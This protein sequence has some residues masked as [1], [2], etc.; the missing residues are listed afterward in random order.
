MHR[1]AGLQ[2]AADGPIRVGTNVAFRAPL[3][4]GFVLGSCRIVDVIDEPN[5]YGFAYGTLPV[6]P[7]CGEEA[8]II[9]RDEGGAV[10]FDVVGVSRPAHPLVRL[11]SP[12]AAGIQDAAVRRYLAA[13]R[14]IAQG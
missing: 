6:H 2:I 11:A 12:L 1:G 4:L 10:R 8:F 14:S 5:L 9:T 3:P 7:E 13:M